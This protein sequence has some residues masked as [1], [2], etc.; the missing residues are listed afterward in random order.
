MGYYAAKCVG[1][2]VWGLAGL[3][4][5]GVPAVYALFSYKRLWSAVWLDGQ[6]DGLPKTN[7]WGRQRVGM[8]KQS[9]VV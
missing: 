7:H 3:I 6:G 9:A 8:H 1:F 4:G 5:M 2:C